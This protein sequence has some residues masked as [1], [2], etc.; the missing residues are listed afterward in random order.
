MMNRR[1]FLSTVSVSLFVTPRVVEAQ[2]ASKQAR[3]GVLCPFACEGPGVE[4]F[5]LAMRDAGYSEGRTL[6]L[7]YR[8]ADGHVDRLPALVADLVHAK[9]DVIF[10]TWGTAAALAA[11]RATATIPV[12]MAAAGD[13]VSAG[14]VSSLARPGANVTG[15][16][17]VA[18]ELEGKRLEL[19]KGVIPKLAR[20]G[21]LWDPESP[22]SVLAIKQEELAA[23]ALDVQLHPVRLRAAADLEPAFATLKRARI[24]ALSVHGYVATLQHRAAIIAFAA[25]SRMP[26]IYPLREFVSEGG[27]VSYGAN[28]AE[29]GRRAAHYVDRIL[30]GAKPAELPVEQPTRLELAINLKT[31]KAL[32][33]TIPPSLLVR[34]DHVIE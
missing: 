29:I 9:V 11:K 13:P 28:V 4:A 19:L 3:V 2:Q 6:A 12:V 20:V 33:L 15:V 16:S 21:V 22:Y 32:G 14:I 5:R 30:R 24:E 27:L 31:A 23:H 7:E 17:S 26:A 10:T 25:A 8:P 34:A 1:R 18:L